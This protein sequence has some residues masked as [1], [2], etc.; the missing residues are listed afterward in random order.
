M[1]KCEHHCTRGPVTFFWLTD[2][3]KIYIKLIKMSSG[4]ELKSDLKSLVDY[5]IN[6]WFIEV[7]QLNILNERGERWLKKKLWKICLII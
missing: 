6:F 7:N 5:F 2:L 4:F 3:I 1:A